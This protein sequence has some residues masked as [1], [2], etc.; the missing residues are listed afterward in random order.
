MYSGL[1]A[2]SDWD[3]RHILNLVGAYRL[4]HGYSVGGRFHYN[5]GRPYPVQGDYQRLPA[6]WQV[7]LRAD[8]R[9]VFDRITFDVFLELGNATLNRQVTAIDAGAMGAPPDQ[10]GFRI[11]LP[12]I[13]VHAEW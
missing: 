13:G 5:T 10:V 1:W 3:Q 8:K 4:P 9:L 6:F 12:S 7:D 11:V 2:P